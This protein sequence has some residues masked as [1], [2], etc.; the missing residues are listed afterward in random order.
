L[1]K[2]IHF[3]GLIILS[4]FYVGC[5]ENKPVYDSLYD[6]SILP[7]KC[8]NID[9]INSESNQKINNLFAPY[10]SKNCEYTLRFSTQKVTKC[11][12]IESR[13][14]GLGF[15]GYNRLEI[16]KNKNIIYKAQSDFVSDIN[17]SIGRIANKMLETGILVKK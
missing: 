7:L 16:Y 14:T 3:I 13:T 12:A 8:L 1:H 4:V 15:S 9:S 5:T 10:A 6:K 17:G 2:A 11:S